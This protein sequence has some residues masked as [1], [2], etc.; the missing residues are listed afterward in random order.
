M[1]CADDIRR[2]PAWPWTLVQALVLLAASILLF[3]R[4]GHYAL[5]DDEAGTA[6]DAKGILLTGDTSALVDDHNI[7]AVRGGTELIHLRH[8]YVPPLQS[9]LAA[10]FLAVFG[11]ESA[12]VARL[13]FTL[14]ALGCVLFILWWMR[15]SSASLLMFALMGFGLV[16]NVSFLLYGRQCRYYAP[17]TLFSIIII[18]CHLRRGGSYKI[19][20]LETA[21]SVLLFALNYLEYFALAACLIADWFI[22]L[23]RENPIHWRRSAWLIVPQIVAVLC[24]GSIWNPFATHASQGIDPDWWHDKL[25]LLYWNIRDMDRAEFCILPLMAVAFFFCVAREA[26]PLMKRGLL[27]MVIYIFSITATSPQPVHGASVAD[28]RYLAPLIPLCLALASGTILLLA[29]GRTWLAVTFGL[30]AFGTNL[31]NGGPL[32]WCGFRSTIAC[33]VGELAHPPG[34]PFTTA[35]KW[36]DQNVRA[37]ESIVV[38]PDNIT[39]PLMFHQPKAIYAWQLA[40]NNHDPQFAGLPDIHFAR[41]VSPD[42]IIAFGP[43]SE[44][45]RQAIASWKNVHYEQAA[46]L[47]CFWKEQFR[48][49][50]FNHSFKAVTDYDKKNEAIYVFKRV[51]KH[52]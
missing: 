43:V 11:T 39:Y 1:Q 10:P 15:R 36:I 32:L 17:A 22:F 52:G 27:A 50:L 21:A 25:T 29:R 13:P 48:P 19:L 47:D 42:Y 38:T 24:I 16:L 51:H 20:A 6:L 12:F 5:W 26:S 46:L 49:E 37:D 14:S 2:M 18:Y 8:R 7:V 3:S 41:R 9:Y 34:D 40:G 23:R 44:Q 45:V 30:L 4:L 31:F 28:I 35:A 33:Y